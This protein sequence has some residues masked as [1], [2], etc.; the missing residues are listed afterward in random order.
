MWD[1]Y[2][3]IFYKLYPDTIEKYI[4]ATHKVSNGIDKIPNKEIEI[5][6]LHYGLL[7]MLNEEKEYNWIVN[8]DI[9]YYFL[10]SELDSEKYFQF[11]TDNYILD[12]LDQIKRGM[13]RVEVVTIALSPEMCGGWDNSIRITKLISN[14]L[15][16]NIHDS[17]LLKVL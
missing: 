14:H 4:F 1:N 7:C 16:L 6:D 10:N 9:D 11:L 17:S 3:P 13:D 15:N 12:I 5:L 2:L 8:L